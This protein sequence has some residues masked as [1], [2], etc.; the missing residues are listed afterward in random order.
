MTD[1]YTIKPLVWTD[2]EK[3]S[4]AKTAFGNY[5]ILFSCGVWFI[6][7]SPT[8]T[9][10]DPEFQTAEQAKAACQEHWEGMIKQALVPV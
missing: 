5:E 8:S 3:S 10:D 1:A 7:I 2:Y 6:S 4:R 9:A